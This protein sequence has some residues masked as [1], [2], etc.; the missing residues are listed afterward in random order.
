MRTFLRVLL[1]LLG[2]VAGFYIAFNTFTKDSSGLELAGIYSI[3]YII[4]GVTVIKLSK[5]IKE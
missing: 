3:I 5:N 2:I 1:S 4:S